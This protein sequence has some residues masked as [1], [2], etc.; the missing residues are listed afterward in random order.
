MKQIAILLFSCLILLCFSCKKQPAR[1]CWQITDALGNE[2]NIVCDKTETEL[3]ECLTNRTCGNT[4]AT[5]TKC[6]YYI[7]GGETFCCLIDGN[8]HENVTENK[9]EYLKGCYGIGTDPVVER[10]R[11]G[12]CAFWYVRERNLYKPTSAITYSTVKRNYLCGD[13]TLTLFQGRQ[14]VRKDDADSLIVIQFSNNGS[15]W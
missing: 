10:V 14:I 8:Y 12:Y 4:G 9:V 1:H 5:V 15:D 3:I 13:T 7:T 2:M 11:C 6:N